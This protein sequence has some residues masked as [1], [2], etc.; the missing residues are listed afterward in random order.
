MGGEN[1]MEALQG[2]WEGKVAGFLSSRE[3]L[4][5][6]Y[7]PVVQDS[8]GDMNDSRLKALELSAKAAEIL[9][10]LDGALLADVVED[11]IQAL[12]K[13]DEVR[14]P[15]LKALA[16]VGDRSALEAVGRVFADTAAASEVRVA[17]AKALGSIF[18]TGDASPDGEV[19]TALQV[20]LTE[21]DAALRLAAAEA[22][23]KA[24]ELA[25]GDIKDILEANRIQ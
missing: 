19:M 1:D 12:D 5:N 23:G 4:G 22:L 9:A 2:I 17:A 6:N 3:V 15:V 14:L 7:L 25:G 11:L 18:A 13:P 24:V 20:A 8:V 21:D 10:L 16:K